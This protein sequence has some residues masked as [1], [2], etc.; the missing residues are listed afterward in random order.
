MPALTGA[1]CVLPPP[2][3]ISSLGNKSL[4][5]T[6]PFP[7]SAHIPL[8]GLAVNCLPHG[9]TENQKNAFPQNCTIIRGNGRV[10]LTLCPATGK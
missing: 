7:S 6:D 2:T 3:P 5:P 8:H 9:L 10:C 4:L 1:V